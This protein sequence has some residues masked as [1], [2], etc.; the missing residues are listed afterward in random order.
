MCG[1]GEFEGFMTQRLFV[2]A[3]GE[4]SEELK[5]LSEELF[6]VW[7]ASSKWNQVTECPPKDLSRFLIEPKNLYLLA[8][9]I[10]DELAICG[11][12]VGEVTFLKKEYANSNGFYRQQYFRAMKFL[13]DGLL[14][15]LISLQHKVFNL[16]L[17]TILCHPRWRV[18]DLSGFCK[19]IQ[20]LKV[21]D[22]SLP[23]DWPSASKINN[24]KKVVEFID[25]EPATSCYIK[26]EELAMIRVGKSLVS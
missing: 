11:S 22:G 7:K 26:L 15:L 24:L 12:V 14:D 19:E 10:S 6:E 17:R 8:K 1:Q 18:A 13:V 23:K 9:Q 3:E 16:I 21:H 25:C 2:F 4:D 5:P 20:S